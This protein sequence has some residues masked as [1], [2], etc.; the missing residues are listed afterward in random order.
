MK[1]AGGT[2]NAL[3]RNWR[4]IQQS[5]ARRAT[6]RHARMR[7]LVNIGRWM[8]VAV[9]GAVLVGAAVYGVKAATEG[10]GGAE[11]QRVL[12]KVTFRTD[13]VLNDAWLRQACELKLGTPMDELNI[14]NLKLQLESFGQVREARL[15]RKLPDEL[16]VEVRERTPVL[17]AR[18]GLADGRTKLVLIARDGVVFDG[19]NYP[20]ETIRA[21]PFLAGVRFRRDGDGIAPIEGMDVVADLLETAR[22]EQ[23]YIYSGWTILSLERFH[24]DATRPGSVIKVNSRHVGEIVFAPG[25]FKEQIDRLAKVIRHTLSTRPREINRIDLS[26]PEQA[27]VQ[28][29]GAKNPNVF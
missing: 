10:T 25:Q 9:L 3:K 23:P 4:D 13:G 20:S 11:V 21:L 24:G 29:Q 6:T 1:Q 27:V 16:V 15:T 17:R 18:V 5:G 12:A 8:L 22:R 28:Y 14:H 26:L 7:R 2:D 19:Y